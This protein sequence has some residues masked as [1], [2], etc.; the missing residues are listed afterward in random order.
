MSIALVAKMQ[1]EEANEAL[2][3]VVDNPYKANEEEGV[4]DDESSEID[5]LLG[6]ATTDSIQ[7]AEFNPLF[8][9]IVPQSSPSALFAILLFLI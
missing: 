1:A 5:E 4:N 6:K 8:D 9:L 2:K 7:P 3:E